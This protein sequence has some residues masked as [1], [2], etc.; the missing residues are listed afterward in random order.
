[1]SVKT[2]WKLTNWILAILLVLLSLPFTTSRVLATR[3]TLEIEEISFVPSPPLTEGDQIT[4]HAKIT[5]YSDEEKMVVVKFFVDGK[6]C[7]SDV[8]N[9]IYLKPHFPTPVRSH[10]PWT[11][12]VGPH[13]LEIS[14]SEWCSAISCF[15]V[16]PT[17]QKVRGLAR[18][19][20]L[21]LLGT[22]PYSYGGK[23][24]QNYSDISKR[25]WATPME[26]RKSYEYFDAHK[27]IMDVVTGTGVDCSGLIIWA[28]NTTYSCTGCLVPTDNENCPSC[29]P[30]YCT[31]DTCNGCN[32]CPTYHYDALYAYKP[33]NTLCDPYNPIMYEG[34]GKNVADS[35]Q[36]NDPHI[37][38]L[39]EFRSDNI[40]GAVTKFM[41]RKR[42]LDM[43]PGDLIYF[44][45]PNTNFTTDGH[46]MMVL[47][48]GVV[49]QSRGERTS[50][51]ISYHQ[52]PPNGRVTIELLNDSVRRLSKEGNSEAD[53]FNFVG[54][55][56]FTW[57]EDSNK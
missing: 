28:Y 52:D 1:M 2:L 9:R 21:R 13:K 39:A 42:S 30:T 12:T 51:I 45:N 19:Q 26:I 4:F 50:D 18:I 3:C 46:V 55:G 5:N 14:D 43:Q 54:V 20:A 27:D 35:G 6:E 32:G 49:I 22:T 48:P 53:W 38:H 16:R 34:T 23:G 29:C 24:W 7:D 37:K 47:V 57:G 15:C 56:R 36:W 31:T 10:S 40:D 8:Q 17:E 41:K 25:R 11:A 33:P 44:L